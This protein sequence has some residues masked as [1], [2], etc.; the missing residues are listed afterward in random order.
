MTY[1]LYLTKYK[2]KFEK[3]NIL[4]NTMSQE[5]IKLA[6]N[7]EN[8]IVLKA[9][10][11]NQIVGFVMMQKSDELNIDSIAVNKEFRNL[12]VA[13]KLI[14]KAE[15][16]A[17]HN[18]IKT[19][20]LEVSYKNITAFLL[21]EKLGFVERRVRKSYYADGVDAIEMIKKI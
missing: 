16:L 12:G 14:Q 21:Y 20:S 13:T 19:L 7:N 10:L 15:E 3:N 2:Y 5:Q 8:Y 17:K 1:L 4:V 9:L 6:L 11:N 18:N